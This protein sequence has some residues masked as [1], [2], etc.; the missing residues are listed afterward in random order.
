MCSRMKEDMTMNLG[1]LGFV[2][3]LVVGVALT[4]AGAL[5]EP[6]EH[7]VRVTYDGITAIV[8]SSFSL[9]FFNVCLR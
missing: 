9:F 8:T 2:V 6:S 4:V 5:M 7:K 1:N 3:I